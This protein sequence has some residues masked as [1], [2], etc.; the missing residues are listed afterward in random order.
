MMN[1][2]LIQIY[3]YFEY[4]LELYRMNQIR[5]WFAVSSR[6]M[7]GLIQIFC[8]YPNMFFI[9]VLLLYHAATKAFFHVSMSGRVSD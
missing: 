8:P 9:F 7:S 2:D 3:V 5:N 6:F 1:M 4:P